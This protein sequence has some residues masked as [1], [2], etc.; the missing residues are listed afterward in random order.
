MGQIEN[1]LTKYGLSQK[2][3]SIY[4]ACIS[5]GEATANEIAQKSQV[6]RTLTYDILE[7]LM[8]MGL[9]SHQLQNGVKSF[10]AADPD[11]LLHILKEK[12]TAI[13][14]AMPELKAIQKQTGSRRPKISLYVGKDGMKTV[15]N[16]ILRSNT[17][18]FLAYGSSR[19]S[20]ELIPAFMERWHQERIEKGVLMRAI[21]NDT[22]QSRQRIQKYQKSLRLSEYRV[23]PITLE[24]PTATLIY[25]ENVILQ[26][27]TPEPFAVLIQSKEMAENQREYFNQLWKVIGSSSAS[28]L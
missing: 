28:Y 22:K 12:E 24:S 25:G 7:R 16:N 10:A 8:E 3:A 15:M 17:K 26:S 9:I 27:W 6:P 13:R 4:A 19:S 14:K 11:E 18:E 23:S 2:E 20:Y 21:Y 1:A 5:L